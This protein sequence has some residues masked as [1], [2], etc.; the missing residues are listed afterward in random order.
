[1]QKE[2]VKHAIEAIE[3]VCGKCPICSS[4]CP[5]AISLRAMKGLLYD[6]EQAGE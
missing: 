3:Q 6:L 5:V 2:K 4:D 1:M